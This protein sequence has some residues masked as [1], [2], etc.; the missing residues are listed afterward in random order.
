MIGFCSPNVGSLR[1]MQNV[2]QTGATTWKPPSVNS[3]GQNSKV[4]EC[5][6]ISP[7]ESP[8][9]MR[10]TS[11]SA[12]GPCCAEPRGRVLRS[13]HFPGKTRRDRQ[14]CLPHVS[15]FRRLGPFDVLARPGINAE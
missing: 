9:H 13:A 1:T 7:Q 3:L 8:S 15:L 11:D 10:K 12:S 4:P 14:E 5:Q 6:T 2:N